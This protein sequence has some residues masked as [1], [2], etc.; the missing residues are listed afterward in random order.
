MSD[1]D[2]AVEAGLKVP[3]SEGGVER[4]RVRNNLL[5]RMFTRRVAPV[6]VDRYRIE[7]RI[8]GGGQGDVYR[9]RD[10][11][12]DRDVAVK[13]LHHGTLAS[14]RE[15]QALAKLS[16]P[17][18]V[19]VFATGRTERGTGYLVTEL[20]EGMPLSQWFDRAPPGPRRLQVLLECARG[21]AAAHNAGLVHADFKPSNVLIDHR[22]RALVI[23][24]G[25]A[26][27]GV[28][29]RSGDGTPGYVAP[30][31]KEGRLGPAA[32]Q[33]AWCIV[34]NELLEG[35]RISGRL[36]RA[37]NKGRCDDPQ[38]R[39]DSMA[40][41][42]AELE[43]ELKP[44]RGLAIA[45]LV[46]LGALS[47]F[48]LRPAPSSPCINI[49][50]AS[51]G[52]WPQSRRDAL[53]VHDE[54]L[55]GVALVDVWVERWDQRRMEVCRSTSPQ[56]QSQIRCLQ[57]LLDDLDAQVSQLELDDGASEA[58][59]Q[60][61]KLELPRCDRPPSVRDGEAEA[62]AIDAIREAK[63][64]LS[65]HD[66]DSASAAL[67]GVLADHER[68]SD[69]VAAE[70]MIERGDAALRLG[71]N[72]I[73]E[74]WFE[75]AV[76]RAAAGGAAS[77]EAVAGARLARAKFSK[78]HH[79]EAATWIKRAYAAAVRDDQPQTLRVVRT[80]DA[81][82]AIEQGR[83][84]DALRIASE[85]L[86]SADRGSTR[87]TALGIICAAYER[88]GQPA[89]AV[90]SCSQGVD[91]ARETFGESHRRTYRRMHSLGAALDGAGRYEQ[92]RDVLQDAV[93]GLREL[94]DRAFPTALNSLGVVCVQLED[95]DG[96]MKAYAEALELAEEGEQA[97]MIEAL[98]INLGTLAVQR[99]QPEEAERYYQRALV[100][101]GDKV[102]M[103]V[104]ARWGLGD[105]L[106]AQKRYA[107]SE[108]ELRVALKRA[109]DESLGVSIH[110]QI[111]VGLAQTLFEGEIDVAEAALLAQET[112]DAFTA[113]ELPEHRAVIDARALL[114]R[115]AGR[116]NAKR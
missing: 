5:A 13:V 47:L 63:L 66:P 21:L 39:F 35:V 45:G 1:T 73:A 18:I 2:D 36:T 100:S 70:A 89:K 110:G 22:G 90:Q 46:S 30:E 81:G 23:D 85:I 4:D 24:F 93:A 64:A 37:L 74:G 12:L 107:E 106:Y 76:W 14:R 61:A 15:A 10:P 7:E 67:D 115:I 60:L 52:V 20:V 17:N 79:D 103:A 57:D 99:G 87:V 42:I 94:G 29:T 48:A 72:E 56:A 101:A 82:I 108:K 40:P 59:V 104:H 28:E 71:E 49:D 83:F 95:L 54:R 3:P 109:L 98:N 86:E 92:A 113:E 34:A 41:L 111:G 31:R 77:F 58:I 25:I 96:A 16:H 6:T 43:V 27:S 75:S 55:A 32:D 8:G 112:I 19:S 44:R 50:A 78:G 91:E 114:G 105:A 88:S 65:V 26:A 84:D 51:Q 38:E 97:A 102:P 9:A 62:A 69:A 11:L 116:E 68:L 80:S 33:Y 53:I